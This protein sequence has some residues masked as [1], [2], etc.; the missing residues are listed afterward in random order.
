M[1]L[2]L[3]ASCKEKSEILDIIDFEELDPGTEG[4]WN[5]SGEEGGFMSGNGWFVNNY[6]TEWSS[7]SGFS[8]TNHSDNETGDYTNMYSSVTGAG[9]DLS[10][11][12]STYY[13]AGS[14]DTLYFSI[15]EKVTNISIS[16]ST[17]AYMTMLY[18]DQFAKK[19][20]GPDGTDPDWFLVKLTTLNEDLEAV[21]VY[22][23][24]LAD[25]R[26][27]NNLLDYISNSWNRIDLSDAGFISGI[28]FQIESS[29]TGEYGINTPAFVCIDDIT[30]LLKQVD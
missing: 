25:F 5:G 15:P 11:V 27:E 20:G 30:G 9:D 6:N 3:F 22:N 24:Y 1:S 29:D 2:L 17:Y 7:W 4:F 28:V 26:S 16:N 10:K 12:Y 18:G 14:A 8:Y 13:Y 21:I 19:F 23:I